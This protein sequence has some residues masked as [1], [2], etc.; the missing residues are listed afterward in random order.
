MLVVV[1]ISM[2]VQLYQLAKELFMKQVKFNKQMKQA[3]QQFSDSNISDIHYL[4]DSFSTNKYIAYLNCKVL[5]KNMNGYGFTLWGKN[6]FGFSAGFE[7]L[8]DND[9]THFVW[10]TK[11]NSR[12]C[13]IM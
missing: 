5:C 13:I 8:D 3:Y 2:V 7:Y 6:T 1:K 12:D 4:Y 9:N 11:D 10:L